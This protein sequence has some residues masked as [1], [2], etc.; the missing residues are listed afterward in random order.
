[1]WPGVVGVALAD[2][3]HDELAAARPDA[4]AQLLHRHERDPLRG[5]VE[6]LRD[7]LAAGPV[8]AQRLGQMIR[9]AEIE[10]AHLLDEGGAIAL[11]E[12]RIVGLLLADRRHR[13]VLVVVPGVDGER[14]VELQQL[15]EQAVVERLGIAGRQIGPP[16]GAAEQRVARQHAVGEHERDRVL[17]VARR[18]DGAHPQAARD[19]RLAVVDP[20]V[21]V[22]RDARAVHDARDAEPSR[23]LARRRE[24]IRVRVRV[25]D[26]VDAD[27]GLADERERAI[28]LRQLGIDHHAGAG[29]AARDHVRAAA[30]GC[31]SPRRSC[32][33]YSAVRRRDTTA[34]IPRPIAYFMPAW[35][36]MRTWRL[37]ADR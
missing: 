11:L 10:G 23:E 1:M 9:H 7:R 35:A 29:L 4:L 20:H 22:G 5:L 33:G 6:Q 3:E 34:A 24:V 12:A 36:C 21:D 31:G 14:L 15:P 32:A 16:G 8:G 26:V 27:A 30:A 25:D 13:R 37:S 18:G 17:G 2:V 28:D 19:E